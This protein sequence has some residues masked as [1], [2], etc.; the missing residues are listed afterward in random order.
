ALYFHPLPLGFVP[1]TMQHPIRW[2]LPE[3]VKVPKNQEELAFYSVAALSVLLK[4]RQVTSEALTQMYLNR[5][6]K[7]GDTL[8]CVITL[9]E[10]L[11]LKQARRADREIAAG[12]YRGPLHG[13]PYGIKDLFAVEGYK[14]TWGAAP[15]KDQVVEGT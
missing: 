3:E 5:L 15:Y 14:T 7:Y 8:Q 10:E 6:K 11:A 2:K 4:S 12:Q 1:D 13:I 9:T